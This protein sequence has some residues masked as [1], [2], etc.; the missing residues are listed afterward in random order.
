LNLFAGEKFSA[1]FN[2]FLADPN[3]FKNRE[4]ICLSDFFKNAIELYQKLNSEALE[5]KPPL[6][7]PMEIC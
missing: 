7:D 5:R 6:D 4:D 3:N 2:L 1:K